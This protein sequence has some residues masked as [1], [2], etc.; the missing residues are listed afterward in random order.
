[1]P[2]G[3]VE[4]IMAAGMAFFPRILPGTVQRMQKILKKQVCETSFKGEF[5]EVP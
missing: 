3:A 5:T 2:I 1:M 4:F